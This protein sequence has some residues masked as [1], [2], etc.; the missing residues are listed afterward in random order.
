MH[1]LGKTAVLLTTY[2]LAVPRHGGQ[3]RGAQ[4]MKALERMGF[5]VVAIGVADEKAYSPNLLGPTDFVFP[6]DSPFRLVNDVSAPYANDYLSGLYAAEDEHAYRRI[7]AS[8]PNCIDMIV[9]EQPWMLPVT[10]RLRRDRDVGLLIYD[11]QNNETALKAPILRRFNKEVADGLIDAILA[12]EQAACREADLVFSVSASDQAVLSRYSSTRVLLATNGVEPWQA[13]E[14]ELEKWRHVFSEDVPN[15]AVYIA[16]AHPPNYVD[17]FDVFEDRFGFLSPSEALCVFGGAAAPIQEMLKGRDYEELTRSRLRFPGIVETAALAAIKELARAFVLPI[18]DGSG[19]N[20]KTAEA[21]FSCKW[22]VGTPT[23]FRGFESLTTLP[24]VVVAHPG[25]EFRDAVRNAM[26]L[27]P[28]SISQQHR[29]RLLELTWERTLAP[30]VSAISSRVGVDCATPE[31]DAS[32][33]ESTGSI[34]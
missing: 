30:M 28:P 34:G 24:H 4:V 5:D 27:P 14:H 19:S 26:A 17:F 20:L 22:V 1:K 12:Q 25:R 16:S 21:L 13:S 33:I 6:A 7:L 32:P 3:I 11:S 2:P 29:Q 18:L 31:P 9:L 15:F 23:S 8:L 10:R